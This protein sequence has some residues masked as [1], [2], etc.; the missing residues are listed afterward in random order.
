MV[1]QYRVR[2]PFSNAQLDDPNMDD[3]PSHIIR[4]LGQIITVS[5]K[6]IKI[7]EGMPVWE[8]VGKPDLIDKGYS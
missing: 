3:D 5:L 6:S 4:L 2:Q 1:D 7:I 8:E